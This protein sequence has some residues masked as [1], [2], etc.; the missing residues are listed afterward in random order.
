MHQVTFDGRYHDP[1]IVEAQSEVGGSLPTA[2]VGISTGSGVGP[3]WGF[4]KEFVKEVEGDEGRDASVRL[5]CGYRE[6]EDICFQSD[7]DD[8]QSAIPIPSPQ[9][10]TIAQASA[11]CS[12]SYSA[13]DS[14]VTLRI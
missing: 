11:Y 7:M 14:A 4:A 10:S 13:Y 6:R 5:F 2:V 9:P 8:L 1:I 12:S 3:L